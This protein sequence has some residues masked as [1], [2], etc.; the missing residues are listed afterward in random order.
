MAY[1]QFQGAA[2]GGGH[3][4]LERQE[5]NH[6]EVNSWRKYTGNLVNLYD[7]NLYILCPAFVDDPQTQHVRIGITVEFDGIAN[8]DI[9][10]ENDT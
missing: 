5:V 1:M 9:L 6:F 3:H 8:I 10:S 2:G 7:L 4:L